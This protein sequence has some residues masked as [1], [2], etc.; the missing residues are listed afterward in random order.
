MNSKAPS[1]RRNEMEMFPSLRTKNV[2]LSSQA[3]NQEISQSQR[4]DDDNG[5]GGDGVI[6]R[7]G[8]V[9]GELVLLVLDC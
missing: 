8:W 7:A 5:G 1:T 6:G 4:D 3:I 2:V 9:L